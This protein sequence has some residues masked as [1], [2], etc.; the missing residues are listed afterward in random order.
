M[1]K[2]I[3]GRGQRPFNIN[4]ILVNGAKSEGE[5]FI[6]N[7]FIYKQRSYNVYDLIDDLGKVHEYMTLVYRNENGEILKYTDLDVDITDSLKEGTFYIKE[8]DPSRGIFGFSTLYQYKK[9]KVHNGKYIFR[10]SEQFD[11]SLLAVQVMPYSITMNV[12]DIKNFDIRS[13]PLDY[14]NLVGTWKIDSPCISPISPGRTSE[15]KVKAI[16]TGEAII[17]FTPDA[18]ATLT[19]FAH[20]RVLE[21]PVDIEHLNIVYPYGGQYKGYA[22]G[23]EFTLRIITEPLNA[24]PDLPY[25]DYIRYDS[26]YLELTNVSSDNKYFTFKVISDRDAV[27][28][29]KYNGVRM[30]IVFD[31]TIDGVQYKTYASST[32]GNISIVKKSR[33]V[34]FDITGEKR[35][36]KYYETIRLTASYDSNYYILEPEDKVEWMVR[37]SQGSTGDGF[38]TPISRFECDYTA[39]PPPNGWR[40]VGVMFNDKKFYKMTVWFDQRDYAN[41]VRIAP[42]DTNTLKPGESVQLS[43]LYDPPDFVPPQQPVFNYGIWGDIYPDFFDITPDGLITAKQEIPRN[44]EV[45]AN[46]YLPGVTYGNT[47][48]RKYMA[49]TIDDV[50]PTSM[51]VRQYEAEYVIPFGKDI[52]VAVTQYPSVNSYIKIEYEWDDPTFVTEDREYNEYELSNYYSSLNTG[53]ELVFKPT[54]IGTH[55]I[56]F[57]F[58]AFPDMKYSRTFTVFQ[59][60]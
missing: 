40:E 26:E 18:N 5:K 49:L 22:L 52:V 38:V 14:N 12:G 16:S 39:A 30:S 42:L 36:A 31:H 11:Y 17:S 45:R 57:W 1:G 23:E 3:A 41:S 28:Y 20:V 53:A 33:D 6:K 51:S 47:E 2:P 15:F 44:I 7:I 25:P 59:P 24:R 46:M 35:Y 10:D 19:S 32:V 29:S 34:Q 21:K 50:K 55:T 60:G 9:I 56:T 4:G 58:T 48:Y 43:V 8:Q 27:E 37:K 13:I 54:R